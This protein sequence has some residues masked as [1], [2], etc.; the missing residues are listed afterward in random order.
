MLLRFAAVALLALPAAASAQ[1]ATFEL[2]VDGKPSG[3]DVFTLSKDK[4]GYKLSSRFGYNIHAHGAEFLD[5]FK[6]SDAYAYLE[7]SMTDKGDGQVITSYVP[8]KAHTEMSIS[9]TVNGSQTSDFF[10]MKSDF[11][12]LPP[13]DAG[14]AQALLLAASQTSAPMAF[15]VYSPVA[16]GSDGISREGA[17][18][19]RPSVD[20]K[21]SK[22]PDVAGTMDGKP[23]TTSTYLLATPNFHWIFYADPARTLLQ[24]DLPDV[25]IKYVHQGFVLTEAAPAIT[26][27]A[28]H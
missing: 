23:V 26:A 22:G 12:L 15:N 14:A 7:G 18:P 13:F 4:H 19:H 25:K 2:V 21:W 1:S 5:E 27:F 17:P 16:G 10:A 3:K 24:C 6:F 9:R 11:V 8:N 28:A 20:A